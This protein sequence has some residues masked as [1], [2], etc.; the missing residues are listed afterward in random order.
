V[1]D[2]TLAGRPSTTDLRFGQIAD[3]LRA[4]DKVMAQMSAGIQ[5]IQ[6][7]VGEAATSAALSNQ[8]RSAMRK[9]LEDLRRTIVGYMGHTHP[10]VDEI[11]KRQDGVIEKMAGM[12]SGIYHLRESLNT[13]TKTSDDHE[14]RL[15][16]GEKVYSR[17]VW[18]VLAAVV[19]PL[20]LFALQ[21][22]F[23]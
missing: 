6:K 23:P 16:D 12:D 8:D 19:L 2:D 22:M 11:K 17:L 9:D 18:L 4:Q 10:M 14:T 20:V 15:R 21:R 3:Q 13:L 5:E 7:A 1:P